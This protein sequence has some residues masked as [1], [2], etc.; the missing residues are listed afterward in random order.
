MSRP[1]GYRTRH[2]RRYDLDEQVGC[3][4]HADESAVGLFHGSGPHEGTLSQSG[5][6]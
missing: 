6:A 1:L 2:G 3:T 4:S 5:L